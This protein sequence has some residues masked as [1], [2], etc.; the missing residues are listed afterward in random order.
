MFPFEGRLKDVAAV[1]HHSKSHIFEH[2]FKWK[3]VFVFNKES[4]GT[5]ILVVLKKVKLGT[6]YIVHTYTY[7]IIPPIWKGLI[8]MYNIRV[9][10]GPK[11]IGLDMIK[12]SWCHKTPYW[13]QRHVSI[14]RHA[15]R[16]GSCESLQQKPHL[17]ACLQMETCLHIK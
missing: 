6:M 1:N 13:I 16:C 11:R 4:C 5:V 8:M 17:W 7:I 12:I 9:G 10:R 15:E 3:H 2:A 14:W